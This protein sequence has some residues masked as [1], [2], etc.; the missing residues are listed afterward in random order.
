MGKDKDM[1]WHSLGKI[2]V[3]ASGT[4]VRI[5]SNESSPSTRYPT[6]TIMI[7]QLPAN[8]GIIYVCDRANA[9]ISTLTGVVAQI[10]IPTLSGGVAAVL[11]YATITIPTSAAPLNAAEYYVDADQNGEGCL[12]S[13]ARN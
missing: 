11:P 5:T 4:P 13:T 12:V 7:Q 9:D 1:A 3:T 10:P 2:T 6:Q 8:T